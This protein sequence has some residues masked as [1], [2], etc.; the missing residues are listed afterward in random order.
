MH[1]ELYVACRNWSVEVVGLFDVAVP[2]RVVAPGF[3]TISGSGRLVKPNGS[4]KRA[5]VCVDCVVHAILD[6]ISSD[7]TTILIMIFVIRLRHYTGHQLFRSQVNFEPLFLS[8]TGANL[9]I[10]ARGAVTR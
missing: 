3:R 6:I 10:L 5:Q 9:I 2:M 7:H 8:Q 1:N 4:I